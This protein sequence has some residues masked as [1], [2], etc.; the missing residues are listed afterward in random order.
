M[1]GLP[2]P[3]AT[4]RGPRR[5]I[6]RF[7]F[8]D[9]RR[10]RCTCTRTPPRRLPFTLGRLHERTLWPLC[11]REPRV[12]RDAWSTPRPSD[13]VAE[14]AARRAAAEVSPST[15][16]GL[17]GAVA[18]VRGRRPCRRRR[19]GDRVASGTPS[20]SACAAAPA[21]RRC[22]CGCR[23]RTSRSRR[24]RGV[25]RDAEAEADALA[26]QGGQRRAARAVAVALAGRTR[27]GPR[28]GCRR[29]RTRSCRCSRRPS[30][31]ARRRCSSRRRSCCTPGRRRRRP[32]LPS[33]SNP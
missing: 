22:R 24:R 2:E 29:R 32:P 3:L 9:R 8:G 15:W 26:G 17:A 19:Q 5:V 7:T 27:H 11:H 10:S 30:A 4:R 18:P 33:S 25:P 16:P 23:P 28:A 6:L 14:S 1:V 12:A 20:P 21:A 13:G 31:A